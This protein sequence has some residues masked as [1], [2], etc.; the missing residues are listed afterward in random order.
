MI[1]TQMP[2]SL[3]GIRIAIL[4]SDGFE[5]TEFEQTRKALLDLGATVDILAQN[6]E[7]LAKGIQSFHHFGAGPMIRPK[8]LVNEVD[9]RDYHAVFVPGGALSVDYMRCSRMHLA[10]IQNLMEAGKLIATTGHGAWLLADSGVAQGRTLTCWP[11]IQKDLERAGGIWKDFPVVV[12]GNVI[13]SR[14]LEDVN[15]FVKV[16]LSELGKL[17]RKDSA[18]A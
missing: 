2:Q 3:K 5:I 14:H 6:M 7:Q 18:A 4:I 9:P 16:F 17:A 12:D 10:F 8:T 15:Q 11:A 13:T 1:D